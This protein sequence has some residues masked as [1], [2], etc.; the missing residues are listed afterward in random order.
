MNSLK[1]R[2]HA[3]RNCGLASEFNPI[4]NA[5]FSLRDEMNSNSGNPSTPAEKTLQLLVQSENTEDFVAA[6]RLSVGRIVSELKVEAERTE[7][8]IA[9]VEKD[10]LYRDFRDRWEEMT[11]EEKNSG[12]PRLIE[13]MV[14]TVYSCRPY[15][16]RCGDCC[17]RVS[18]SLHPEDLPLFDEGILRFESIYTLRKGEPV[19]DNVRGRLENLPEEIIKIKESPEGRVCVFYEPAGKSCR[20]YER[21]PVQCRTQECWNPEALERLWSGDKLT[22]RHFAEEDEELLG[23]LAVHDARCSPESLDRA[24]KKYWETGNSSDL[25]PVIDMLSQDMIVRDFFLNNMGR[26][27]EELDFLLGRPLSTILEA[28]NLKVEKEDSGDYRLI[29][30]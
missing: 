30:V 20:Y 9:E 13:R 11:A 14:K 6:A 12:W 7:E 3:F 22:R 23:L 5:L 28:Y 1:I 21:R 27:Y 4:Y 29:E 24:V 2:S 19:M 25:D 16:M 18:P 8:I 26:R 15:C 10:A 17:S